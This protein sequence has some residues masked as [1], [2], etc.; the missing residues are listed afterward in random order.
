[1][2]SLPELQERNNVY[3]IR[4]FTNSQVFA[5]DNV[6][7]DAT[8]D[9]EERPPATAEVTVVGSKCRRDQCREVSP[10]Q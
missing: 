5:F 9:G 8:M 7:G 1:M 3:V 10:S 4:G 2:H 6:A